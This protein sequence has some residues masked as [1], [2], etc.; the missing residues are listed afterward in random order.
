MQTAIRNETA[1]DRAGTRLDKA[2]AAIR[3]VGPVNAAHEVSYGLLEREKDHADMAYRSLLELTTGQ[4]WT[5]IAR[6]L[7]L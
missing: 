1:L 4:K 6:W 2:N 5:D 3:A 7:S